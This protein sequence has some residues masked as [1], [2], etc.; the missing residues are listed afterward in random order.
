MT[1]GGYW[2][3]GSVK[4]VKIVSKKNK[5]GIAEDVRDVPQ[6]EYGCS[7]S[8]TQLSLMCLPRRGEVS[9]PSATIELPNTNFLWEDHDFIA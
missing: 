3:L 9:S 5:L 4:C 7:G 6:Q 1:K 2:L 8:L